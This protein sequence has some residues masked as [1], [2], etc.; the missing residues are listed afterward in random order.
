MK[1]LDVSCGTGELLKT[2]ARKPGKWY[3]V[4]ISP[5]MLAVARKKLPA[6]VV[7]KEALVHRLPFPDNYFE[8][9]V[10]TEAFHHYDRQQKALKEMAR[11]TKNGGKVIIVDI[12]FFLPCLH[13]LFQKIEPGCVKINGRKEMQR[14]FEKTGLTN[15]QQQRSFLFAVMT[16]GKK[17]V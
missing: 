2:L 6:S 5:E 16:V 15:I 4:D 8:Y 7:L 1:L 10:S 11:V 12:N 14:L 13:F 9:V 17:E 3:G